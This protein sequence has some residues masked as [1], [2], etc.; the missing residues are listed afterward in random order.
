MKMNGPS[1]VTAVVHV[2]SQL[3]HRWFPLLWQSDQEPEDWLGRVLKNIEDIRCFPKCERLQLIEALLV[4]S[5]SGLRWLGVY[6]ESKGIDAQLISESLSRHLTEL[7]EQGGHYVLQTDVHYPSSLKE[8]SHPPAAISYLGCMPFSGPSCI[9]ISIVGSRK[10]SAVALQLAEDCGA[11]LAAAG[12]EIVSGGAFGCDIAA[13]YG[14]LRVASDRAHTTVVFAGGLDRFHPN[15]HADLFRKLKSKAACFISERLWW[16]TARPFDFIERNRIISGLSP[17]TILIEAP[18]KSGALATC[19]HALE[20]GREVLVWKGMHDDVRSEG[21]RK[22]VSDGAKCFQNVG[23][24]I[25]KL[26]SCERGF[27]EVV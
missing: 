22:L 1:W 9:P 24:L 8:I 19:R 12:W 3:T 18:V 26:K 23:D 27:A 21:N 25:V 14:T 20:Q 6:L 4:D 11:V 13:H 5:L 15:F 2:A 17:V 16:Q 10:A 7:S